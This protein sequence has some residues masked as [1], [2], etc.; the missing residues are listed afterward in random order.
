[1]KKQ[2]QNL[3]N[4]VTLWAEGKPGILGVALV[5]SYARDEAKVDSDVDL[6]LLASTPKELIDKP[7]WI[8]EF[9]D[10][11]SFKIEDWGLVTSL[12]VFYQ[13]VLEVEFGLTTSEWASEPI[14]EGTRQVIADGMKILFDK[15]GLLDRALKEVSSEGSS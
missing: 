11:K 15:S 4:A 13:G 2:V 12:R 5:G 10:V 7:K 8:K 6:V 1:M 14:D 3:L 9:G